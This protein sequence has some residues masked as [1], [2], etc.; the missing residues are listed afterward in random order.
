[1]GER[2]EKKMEKNYN[3]LGNYMGYL[4][5]N[6]FYRLRFLFLESATEFL[7]TIKRN[8]P[9]YFKSNTDRVYTIGRFV[10]FPKSIITEEE[11]KALEK[12]YL[13]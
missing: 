13:I 2:K 4:E 11:L 5:F 6:H 12:Q 9:Q 10:Y 8:C 1:M 3:Y 7:R